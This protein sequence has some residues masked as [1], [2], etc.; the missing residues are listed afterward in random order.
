MNAVGLTDGETG[1]H[2]PGGWGV[3]REIGCVGSHCAKG[4]SEKGLWCPARG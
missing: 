1:R 3:K 2:T 4:L